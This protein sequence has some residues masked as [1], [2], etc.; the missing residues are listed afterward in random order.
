MDKDMIRAGLKAAVLQRRSTRS[1]TG[2]QVPEELIEEIVEA[3]RH[4]PSATNG[5]KT[6]FF[7]VRN[8]EK[9]AELKTV[10]TGVLA[11]I[12]AEKGMPPTLLSLIERANQGEVDVTYGAPTLIVTTNEK[13]SMN[14][15]ADTAVAM[16]NMMLTASACGLANCWINQF[17][18]LRDAPALKAFF[19]GIGVTPNLAVYGA[20][21]VGYATEPLETAPLPRKGNIITYIR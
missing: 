2:E 5:Q 9:L 1:Y 14:A 4:A 20:L 18:M 19:A 3:G 13:G 12:P 11:G 16:E 21:S 7:V 8:A 15:A 6:H 10:M 17:L